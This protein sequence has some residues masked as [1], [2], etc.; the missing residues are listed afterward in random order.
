M[1]K[2]KIEY[3]EAL[4]EAR[5]AVEAWASIERVVP[6]T[7]VMSRARDAVATAMMKADN[8]DLDAIT[9]R[10][11]AREVVARVADDGIRRDRERAREM[12]R[13]WG[14]G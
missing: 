11:I 13:T 3:R 2:P 1:K 10:T 9:T 12:L 8:G 4:A 7:S 14:R 5:I 6:P